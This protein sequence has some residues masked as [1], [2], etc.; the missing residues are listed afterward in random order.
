MHWIAPSEKAHRRRRARK[1]LPGRHRPHTLPL[2]D[3]EITWRNMQT[4]LAQLIR[5]SEE[6]SRKIV[7]VLTTKLN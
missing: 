7:E 5:M 3:E 6:D 4:S 2:H 1:T